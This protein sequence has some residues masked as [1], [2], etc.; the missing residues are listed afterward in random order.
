MASF[1]DVVCSESSIKLFLGDSSS[2]IIDLVVGFIMVV[3]VLMR[4]RSQS[5]C[6]QHVGFEVLNILKDLKHIPTV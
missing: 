3:T 4:N 5:E 6:R 1:L 2:I